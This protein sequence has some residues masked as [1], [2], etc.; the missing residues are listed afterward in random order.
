VAEAGSGKKRRRR[1]VAVFLIVLLAVFIWWRHAGRKERAGGPAPVAVGVAEAKS[2]PMRVTL[3]EL[4]TVT[5]LATV[6]VLPQISGYITGIGFTE[7][8]L[9][10]KGQF[11]VQIDPRP[12]EIQLEQYQAALA[13]DEASLAQ[14]R[15]DLARYEK[16][17]AQD[18][19][20]AQTV[21]DQR[22]LAAQNAAAVKADQANIDSAK[23]DLVYCHITS[24][25]TGRVG[26]R[27]VDLGN[28][29][30]SGS[31]T[32][33]A[34]VTTISPTTVI[35]SVAQQDLAMVLEQIESGA[36]LEAAAYDSADTTKLEDGTLTAVDNQVN[37]STGMVKLRADFPNTDGRLFP[38]QFVNVHLLVKTLQNATLVPSPAVQEG[39]PGAYVYL[40]QP[41]HSVK[42]QPV[43]TGPTDGVNTVITKGVQ[44]GATVVVDGVD[45]LADGS[46]VAVAGSGGQ[47][48]GRAQ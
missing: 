43:E 14:A 41:D 31:S 24:P 10:Q 48:G 7:G 44:P 36:T 40:V 29:V 46:R 1:W 22:F 12:Y 38:N 11:L 3:D 20:S 26:L 17:A 2:G 30:T 6:T 39:A 8:Q 23:L 25:V 16:L 5:P 47:G 34:V 19:I 13:K 18:S 45:R 28:Y 32:G 35:F 4:G 21:S 37:S 15:S 9:V 33:L 27:L 42:M